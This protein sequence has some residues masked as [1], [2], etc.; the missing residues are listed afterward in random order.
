MPENLSKLVGYPPI[1]IVENIEIHCVTLHIASVCDE[2]LDFL[3]S[4]RVGVDDLD[5]IR[6]QHD[7]KKLRLREM[8]K[9][10]CFSNSIWLELGIIILIDCH[11]SIHFAK[12]SN[13]IF[14]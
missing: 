5:S 12:N 7:E 3:G 1:Y 8:I 10:K 11:K 14:A 9:G 4:M 6:N 13:K 2:F